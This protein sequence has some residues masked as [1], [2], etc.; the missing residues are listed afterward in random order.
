M[1]KNSLKNSLQKVWSVCCKA[2]LLSPHSR[3]NGTTNN[4]MTKTSEN[5]WKIRN[6]VIIFVTAFALKGI[7]KQKKEFFEKFTYQ[8][9]VQETLSF[10]IVGRKES[11]LIPSI[12][13]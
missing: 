7:E 2:L 4:K 1:G 9:V 12:V 11:K 6:K 8:Q 3:E 13:N 10:G 5:I